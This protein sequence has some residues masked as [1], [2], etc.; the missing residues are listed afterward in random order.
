VT[1][2]TEPEHV[3]RE[4]IRSRKTAEAMFDLLAEEAETFDTP[5]AR[6]RFWSLLAYRIAEHTGTIDDS[7]TKTELPRRYRP[8]D[9]ATAK[10]FE[11]QTMTFGK[12]TGEPISEV[13]L[14]YLEYLDS[15]EFR[16]DLH[17]YLQ[18]DRVQR[19]Q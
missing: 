4:R 13:P 18:S 2:I 16:W 14:N 10:R 1:T 17:R 15:D 19:E 12:Y 9:E 6:R 11:K 3:T 8:M 7:P 5:E